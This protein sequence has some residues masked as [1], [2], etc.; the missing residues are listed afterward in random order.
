MQLSHIAKINKARIK[1]KSSF[2]IISC[3][4]NYTYQNNFFLLFR[5]FKDPD[6]EHTAYTGKSSRRSVQ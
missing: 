3:Y 6:P 2:T 4:E 1:K 5:Y